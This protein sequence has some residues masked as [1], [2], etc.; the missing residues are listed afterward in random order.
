MKFLLSLAFLI[1]ILMQGTQASGPVKNS[2]SA[3][4]TPSNSDKI[5]YEQALPGY[6]YRFPEDHYS[7]DRYRTEWWYYTGH[8]KNESGR[9]FGF[10]LTFFRS[11]SPVEGGI[12]S[13]AWTL[14]NIYMAHFALSDVQGQKFFNDE[15]LSRSGVGAAGASQ[16]ACKV[17]TEN[18]SL[19]RVGKLHKI[20]AV[21]ADNSLQLSLEESAEPVI[22]GENG[23]S[24]KANCVGCASHYYSFTRMP[25]Q[26]TLKFAGSTFKVTGEAWMDHEFGS[27]QLTAEQVGWDW[28][29]LQL[30]DKTEIMLYAMRLKNSKL[31]PNSS[32]TYVSDGKTQHLKLSDYTIKSSRE[33]KSPHT[34][35]AYPARWHVSIP[36]RKLE[37]DIE[38]QL[39]DQELVSHRNDGISYWEGACSVKGSRGGSPISGRAYVELT[40]YNKNFHMNI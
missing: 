29:S 31:D 34:G 12:K 17:W 14:S 33:W 10:E 25:A 28:F 16:S 35:G 24:Q 39:A 9:E 22:H 38:P 6:K 1:L 15:K 23:V 13:G 37:L 21:D 32:G 19:D 30:D 27:N 5:V 40:G 8:L 2:A 3:D 36:S 18:W 4:S 11:A 7:H 20:R 26:G